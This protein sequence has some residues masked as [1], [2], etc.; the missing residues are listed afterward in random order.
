MFW[1]SLLVLMLLISAAPGISI[2][3]E[4]R[5]GMANDHAGPNVEISSDGSQHAA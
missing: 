4:H 2:Y 3:L 1:I 5:Q